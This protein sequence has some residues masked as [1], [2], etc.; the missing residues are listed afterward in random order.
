[1]AERGG[2]ERARSVVE[3]CGGA[4]AE[5]DGRARQE[6]EEEQLQMTAALFGGSVEGGKLPNRDGEEARV[7]WCRWQARTDVQLLCIVT[8]AS[9]AICGLAVQR[10]S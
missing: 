10:N 6:E 1:M 7:L 9:N 2:V 4:D 8:L 3:G 5:D